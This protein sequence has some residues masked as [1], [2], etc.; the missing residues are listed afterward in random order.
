MTEQLE[1]GMVEMCNLSALIAEKSI[2]KGR[3]EGEEVKAIEI[4]LNLIAGGILSDEQIAAATGL[5][6]D[7]VKDLHPEKL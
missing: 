1:G 7:A 5:S 2:A 6:V 3:A 4:A